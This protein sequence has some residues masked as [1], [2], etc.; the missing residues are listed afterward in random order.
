MPIV[1]SYF[2]YLDMAQVCSTI[3]IFSSSLKFCSYFLSYH[4][5]R[6]LFHSIVPAFR[7]VI[8]VPLIVRGLRKTRSEVCV[9][10]ENDILPHLSFP[11]MFQF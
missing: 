7:N 2:D 9:L 4:E 5:N 3:S 1:T 10:L 6:L 11:Y 8:D